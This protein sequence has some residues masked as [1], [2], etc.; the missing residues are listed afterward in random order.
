MDGSGKQY[1]GNADQA[2]ILKK[3]ID[4]IK[5]DANTDAELLNILEKHI[6]T[7]RPDV[8]AMNQAVAKIQKLAKEKQMHDRVNHYRAD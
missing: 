6:I 5:D 8:D 1:D 3:A 2:G 4:E 7:L